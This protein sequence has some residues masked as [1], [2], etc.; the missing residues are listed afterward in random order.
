MSS[1][2]KVSTLLTKIRFFGRNASHSKLFTKKK[3]RNGDKQ[4]T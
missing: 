4:T 1:G 3:P 2:D